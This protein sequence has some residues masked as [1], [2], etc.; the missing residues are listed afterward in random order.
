[1]SHQAG[2][3]FVPVKGWPLLVKEIVDDSFSHQ[4]PG[5]D[6]EGEGLILPHWQEACV[7]VGGQIFDRQV[8]ICTSK[9]EL[10]KKLFE[11]EDGEYVFVTGDLSHRQHL[12]GYP[13]LQ[14]TLWIENFEVDPSKGTKSPLAGHLECACGDEY[15]DAAD[16]RYAKHC[17]RCGVE[18][19][20]IPERTERY[21]PSCEV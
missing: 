10:A 17:T 8:Y 14:T 2:K 9:P 1:M 7:E 12:A 3:K 5:T 20:N 19:E 18:T 4:E 11:V 6:I 15:T 21:C 16:L 13:H